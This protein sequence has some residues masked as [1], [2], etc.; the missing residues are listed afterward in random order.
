MGKARDKRKRKAKA[1]VIAE[2]LATLSGSGPP[3][4]GE[5]DAPVDAPLKPKPNIRPV[6]IA[7]PEPEWRMRL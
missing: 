3:T 1:R 4:V 2:A 6:A 7:V 5:P